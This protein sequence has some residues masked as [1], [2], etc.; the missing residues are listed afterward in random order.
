[1][2]RWK[3]LL[4]QQRSREGTAERMVS[5]AVQLPSWLC[6][7]RQLKLARTVYGHNKSDRRLAPLAKPT[8]GSLEAALSLGPSAVR[9]LKKVYYTVHSVVDKRTHYGKQQYMVRWNGYDSDENSWV[10][11]TEM[12]AS[13]VVAANAYEASVQ[14]QTTTQPAPRP[15]STRRTR[16]P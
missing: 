11:A 9:R 7:M 1:M 15:R 8:T 10:P 4:P 3:N 6:E 13:A 16:M 5:L 12:I 14:N 2:K